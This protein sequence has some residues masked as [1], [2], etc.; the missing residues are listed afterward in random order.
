ML[1]VDPVIVAIVVV[2]VV[3]ADDVVAPVI[4]DPASLLSWLSISLLFG[5]Q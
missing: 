4:V 1:F 5:F 2:V 3:V